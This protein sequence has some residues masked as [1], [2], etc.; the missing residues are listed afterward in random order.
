MNQKN[1]ETIKQPYQAPIV[2]VLEI[3]V[4]HAIATSGVTGYGDNHDD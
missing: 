4:D 2:E 3:E 1:I